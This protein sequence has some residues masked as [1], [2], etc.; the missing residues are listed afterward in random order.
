L[1]GTG[2]YTC[3]AFACYN[4]INDAD[5]TP[6]ATGALF[7][8]LAWASGVDASG[9][10]TVDGNL[11]GSSF[12]ATGTAA[13]YLNVTGGDYAS[14][15]DTNGQTGASGEIRDLFAQNDFC[16]NLGGG[17]ACGGPVGDWQLL[18]DDPVRGAVIPEPG[19][20][21]LLGISLLG[22][23]GLRRKKLV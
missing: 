5:G 8:S 16:D 3:A 17:A 20:L 4:G 18:S 23:V 6:I 13:G 2:G 9:V 10:T 7:L 14:R 19:T 12:P 22:L 11:I 15:F 21:A 1:Q